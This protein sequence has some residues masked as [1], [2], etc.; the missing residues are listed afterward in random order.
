MEA[1]LKADMEWSARSEKPHRT[2]ACRSTGLSD[3]YVLLPV[4][5][6]V[7]QARWYNLGSKNEEAIGCRL[8]LKNWP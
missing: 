7:A 1:A 2:T 8:L 4:S 5:V 6:D 3:N